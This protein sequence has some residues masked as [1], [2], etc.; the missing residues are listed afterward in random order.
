MQNEV[1][2]DR[3]EAG[4]SAAGAG[5][6]AEA[7][8][9][10]RQTGRLRQHGRA[11][12]WFAMP[13]VLVVGLVLAVPIV[14]AVYYS[15]TNWNGLT[16]QWVGPSQFVSTFTQ[17]GF[18]RVLLNNVLLLLAMPAA[19]LFPLCVA[20][21]LAQRLPG[22]RIFRSLYFLPTAISWVIIGMVSVRF[23][24][25]NGV[26]NHLPT[27]LGLAPAHTNLLGEQYGALA[28]VG[29]TLV[30]SQF[31]TNTIIFMTGMATL[32]P[33]LSEAARVD[34]AGSLRVLWHIVLPQLSRYLQFAFI[35]TVLTAYTAIFSLIFVMTDGGPGYGSTT[36]EFYV[37]Q[38]AFNQDA[39]GEAALLGLVLLVLVGVISLPQLRLIRVKA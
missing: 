36:L 1:R 32:D 33:S 9:G 31:G 8:L 12:I 38:S 29:L 25:T 2:T 27:L 13:S 15:M 6:P 28:A 23:F 19:I 14:E 26:L 35:I 24:A 5:D 17:P 34:G 11:G 16:A 21:I 39:F 10:Q 37:Y 3:A 22:W 18:L 4:A 7:V 20:F 30:W